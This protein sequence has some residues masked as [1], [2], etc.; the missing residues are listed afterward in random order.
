MQDRNS[1]DTAR[2]Q[3][4]VDRFGHLR[5]LVI[6]EAILDS[7]LRGTADRLCREAPV[8]IVS[9][10]QRENLPGGAANTAVNVACLGAQVEFLSVIGDDLQGHTLRQELIGRGVGTQHLLVQEGR[11]TLAKHRVLAGGQILIRFDEGHTHP[12][13]RDTERLLAARLSELFH[14]FDAVIVSDYGYGVLTPDLIATLGHLQAS[15]PTVLVVDSKHLPQY[16]QV[17]VTAIKPNYDEVVRLL[18][19]GQ[20]GPF[21]SRAEWVA[22]H[23]KRLLELTGARI[24][25][26][27]LDTDGAIIIESDGD[28]YRTYARPVEHSLAVGAGDTFASVLA[29][30]L[31]AGAGTHEAAE[32]ASA[33]ASIVVCREGTATCSAHEL[34]QHLSTGHK[35]IP[36]LHHMAERAQFYHRQ[37]KRI[38]FTNGC[39]DILHAGH[40]AFLNRARALG[41]VLVV[42]VNSDRSV[43]RLKG[44]GRPINRLQDRVK[45]LAALDCV[46]HI[47]PFDDDIPTTLIC[48]IKPHVFAKGG[49]YTRDM[50]PEAR[51]VEEMGGRV[52][53]L[54]CFEQGSTRTL[55][56]RIRSINAL[57]RADSNHGLPLDHS[58]YVDVAPP[59]SYN[60]QSYAG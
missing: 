38:V 34:R 41:D 5:C 48:A 6:G 17:G 45:V 52:H 22:A 8:P 10:Q 43:R 32:L 56:E 13:D 18:G 20:S 23:R 37:G 11:C 9:V 7:Y 33:A 53:I 51:T 1:L 47:V 27:T 30:A 21:G 49:N 58:H 36:D 31:A 3:H 29:L 19:S 12:I 55:I 25:A 28:C 54:P 26:V 42:A 40:I 16:R 4:Y 46:D 15:H 39:F 35:Y 24:A 50:L 57:Q 14:C 44:H 59:E 2:L 60:G